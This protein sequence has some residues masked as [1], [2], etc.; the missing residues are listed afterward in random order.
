MRQFILLFTLF[1][2]FSIPAYC[3]SQEELYRRASGFYD[4]GEY[5]K[6]ID[7]LNK[8]LATDP[9]NSKFLLLKGNALEK[10]KKFQEAFDVY[11]SAINSNPKDSYLYNQRGLMLMKIQ[12][13]E[14]S[15]KD[16]ST[17]LEFEKNDSLR[18]SL[19]LNRGSAKISMRNFHGAYDDFIAALQLDG[20]NIGVLN[21]LA[22][23]CDEVGRGDK[24]LSYLNK[25]IEIDSTFIGA[26][27]NIGF[28][29]QEMGDHK[30]AITY[31]N[32]VLKLDPKEPL[33]YSNRSYN[34]Y[35]IGELKGALSDINTS[36]KLYP[37][38]SY[39]YR[40][41][42]LIY[43]AQKDNKNA[44]KDIEEALRLGFTKK[45]GEEVEQLKRQHCR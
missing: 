34:R 9:V 23:V 25:I 12:E 28:K 6:T 36:I 3:Q 21:N 32:K 7:N 30:T 5:S 29:Y 40:I 33:G 19:L 20:S 38:N 1:L 17:A 15:I 27:A 18:L 22:T 41:R 11:T 14:Y 24:T 35:K 31:F 44:C 16:F 4:K 8:A 26:Y 2:L 13:P 45:Y 43:L 37:A 10:L 39:A 42:A